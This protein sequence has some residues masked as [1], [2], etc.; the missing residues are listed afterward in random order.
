MWRAW[1]IFLLGLTFLLGLMSR[2]GVTSVAPIA[3]L[4]FALSVATIIYRPRY[5]IY[6]IVFFSLLGDGVMVPAY[7]FNKNFSSGE[8]LF[9]LHDSVNFNP[10]EVC[11]VVTTLSW[12][13]GGLMQRKLRLYISPLTWPALIF[14]GFILFGL[15]W[16]LARGGNINIALWEARAIFYLPLMV[17][18]VTNLLEKRE[19]INHLL[20]AAML[21]LFIEALVAIGHVH[22]T[23]GGDLTG[24]ERIAEHSMSIHQATLFI[25]AASAWLYHASRTKRIV[26]PLMAPFVLLAFVYNQRRASYLV[27]IFGLILAGVALYKVRRTLFWLITPPL[28]VAGMIYLAAF[29]N[30]G[31]GSLGMPARAVRSVIAPVEGS[32]DDLS[33]LYR[34]TENVNTEFTIRQAPLTGVGF[35][36]KFYVIVPLPDL[37]F[38]IWYEYITH[39][40]ILW[41]WMKTGVG[42]FFSLLFLIGM[43]LMT[44][45]RATWRMPG[46]DMAAIGLTATLYL[47]MHF[48]YAYVD[49]SWETQSMVYVGAMMGVIGVLEH[50]VGV[51]LPAKRRR[52]PWQPDPIPPPGLVPDS[53]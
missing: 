21:A 9:F 48:I 19:H 33:N 47:V 36:H 49:M 42:G 20:W 26:L 28:I 16:G 18:L 52:W 40:S 46:G 3:W 44:G 41:I 29:W 12:L 43:A 15:V 1:F 11:L 7:P 31:G 37:S 4:I 8:S 51:P 13:I 6:L 30:S 34:Q 35:G 14:L 10:V 38:F 17:V 2:Q 32:R 45:V 53:G 5:G 24:V 22:I 23:R 25:L 39:N 27:L 50:V